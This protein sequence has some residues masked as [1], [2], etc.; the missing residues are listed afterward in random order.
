MVAKY[1]NE[2]DMF[3]DVSTEEWTCPNCGFE[4]QVGDDCIYCG[5][6]KKM[7]NKTL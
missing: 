6:S 7:K 2:D 4:V 1:S 3:F 5:I